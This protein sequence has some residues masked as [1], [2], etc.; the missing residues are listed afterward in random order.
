VLNGR[1]LAAGNGRFAFLTIP[2]KRQKE[3]ANMLNERIFTFITRLLT[4]R[5]ARRDDGRH[6]PYEDC[7][8]ACLGPF[9]LSTNDCFVLDQPAERAITL[10]Q[11]QTQD[12]YLA[13]RPCVLLVDDDNDSPDVRPYYTAA[14][15]ALGVSYDVFNAAGGNG[16]DVD[17]AGG[18]GK[19]SSLALPGWR[20]PTPTPPTGRRC[21]S[22]SSIFLAAA[23]ANRPSSTMS[24]HH[25][26]L[27]GR[28]CAGLRR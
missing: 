9:Q 19:R 8:M 3:K 21:S 20:W 12:F 23:T 25:Q 22:A 14:L 4:S 6:S 7:A 18:S 10:A 27:C 24:P 2:L 26:C 1:Y 15:D 13:S 28:F 11:N 17:K 5:W 16:L